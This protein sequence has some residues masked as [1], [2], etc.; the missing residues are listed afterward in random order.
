[1]ETAPGFVPGALSPLD[2]A[3]A[4]RDLRSHALQPFSRFGTGWSIDQTCGEVGTGELAL[5]LARSS[6][7]KSTAMLN[8]IHNTP[9]VPTLVVNMEMTARRQVE[10]LTGMTF[11][12][13]VRTRDIEDVLRA[14]PEDDRHIE[15][16]AAL[17][18]MSEHYQHLHFITP[19]RPSVSDLS[20]V[21]DDIED[22]TGERPARVFIDHLGLMGG[23]DEGYSGYE[24]A[25]S[26]LHSW[27][28]RE[29]LAVWVVQQTGR[30]TGD[31]GR[32]N[33]HVPLTLE[34]G[35]YTGEQHADWVFGLY[36]PDRNPKFK[37]S[38]YSFENPED[39]F[40]MLADLDKVRGIAILQVLKNRP[41]SDILDEG[42]E[43]KFDPHSKCYTEK[44]GVTT[45]G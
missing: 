12:L 7:G 43:L 10:W 32:N 26:G 19:T 14:G 34:S 22:S 8:I 15:V 45:Y 40:T 16:V 30:G 31:G 11:D 39:Y 27:A 21:I 24:R 5:L 9:D 17:D 3:S 38:R 1:M 4:T 29:D 20:F 37:K 18:K 28:M 6:S 13:S 35:L 44:I 2:V 23:C 42:L 25:S 33:G 41:F 36:R